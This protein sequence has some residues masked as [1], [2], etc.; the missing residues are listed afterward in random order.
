MPARSITTAMAFD[1][2]LRRIGVAFA[3]RVTASA[4]S[5][6]TLQ[7]KAGK[8][9]WMA[10]EEIVS[11]WQPDVL[12]VGLPSGP[13]R[14]DSSILPDI[15]NFINTLEQKFQ[16]PVITV[17]ETLTSQEA[18]SRLK[19]QRRLGQKTRKMKKG[20][21]DSLSAQLIAETWLRGR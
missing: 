9:D 3:Q 18:R 20:D 13:Q 7:S 4:R 8:T 15:E 12:I 2:G 16:V 1:F 19:E 17:D 14:P 21:I 10:V 11:Q 5:L 6:T